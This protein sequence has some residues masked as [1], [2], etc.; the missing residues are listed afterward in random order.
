MCYTDDVHNY[1][2]S[3]MEVTVHLP[4]FPGGKN[5]IVKKPNTT[6]I[7]TWFSMC[8]IATDQPHFSINVIRKYIVCS[9]V[10]GAL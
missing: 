6:Q 8:I 7:G 4:A 9:F 5:L 3:S 1:Y 10:G 2:V